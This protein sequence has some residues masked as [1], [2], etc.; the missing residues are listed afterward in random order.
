[1]EETK[2]VDFYNLGLEMDLAASNCNFTATIKPEFLG[3]F[4]SV[5]PPGNDPKVFDDFYDEEYRQ[6]LRLE[7]LTFEFDP[8]GR[9]LDITIEAKPNP[10]LSSEGP[11]NQFRFSWDSQKGRYFTEGIQTPYQFTI[12]FSLFFF[13][14]LKRWL[15]EIEEDSPNEHIQLPWMVKSLSDLGRGLTIV[16]SPQFMTMGRNL[17]TPSFIRKF[18]ASL[19]D[20]L[21]Q[22]GM[23]DFLPLTERDV[24][25]F[26]EQGLNKI[27]VIGN[28]CNL[29]L[30]DI[31]ETGGNYEPHNIDNPEQFSCI[32]FIFDQWA[33]EVK[34][35]RPDPN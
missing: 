19:L 21:K 14:E 16:T 6:R 27:E 8:E 24:V 34:R 29:D 11:I 7:K 17:L 28:A 13:K 3:K 1:M 33:K 18:T 25:K 10:F 2:E 30:R 4:S 9:L 35:V 23:G 31:E 12:V 15:W 22:K 32:L 26:N 20:T 5:R